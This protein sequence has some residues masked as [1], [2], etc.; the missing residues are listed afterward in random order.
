[1]I[2]T[3][4]PT[5]DPHVSLLTWSDLC[6]LLCARGQDVNELNEFARIADWDLNR[7]GGTTPLEALSSYVFLRLRDSSHPRN[8]STLISLAATGAFEEA[9]SV[10]TDRSR[11]PTLPILKA[12]IQ[13][14]RLIKCLGYRVIVMDL[15][16]PMRQFWREL[17][18]TVRREMQEPK[19]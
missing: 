14:S 7:K 17:A 15:A 18:Q 9:L 1:M 8:D 2:P 11:P 16:E 4:K 6:K 19:H 12:E 5:F 3:L 13:N 10:F